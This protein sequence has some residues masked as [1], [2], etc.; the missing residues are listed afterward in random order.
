MNFAELTS[1]LRIVLVNP[2]DPGNIGAAA[3]A[4]KTMGLQQLYIVSPEDFPN[5]KATVR[6]GNALDILG[7]AVVVNTLEEAIGDCHVVYGTSARERELNWMTFTAR[8][9]AAKIFA[10]PVSKKIAIVFGRERYGL[11]NTELQLCNYRLEIPANPEYSSL[12]LGAAVQVVCYELRMTG[13]LSNLALI[14]RSENQGEELA[15]IAELEYFYEHLERVLYAI[16]F[17]KPTRTGQIMNRLRRL[18]SRAQPDKNEIDILR[19]ML[20]AT[21]KKL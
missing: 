16:E 10:E 18:Y 7:G 21:E 8:E 6:A 17:I 2:T 13:M 5:I 15:T 20:T 3:R 9:A 19:G 11:T 4:I 14:E 12:N 1:Q